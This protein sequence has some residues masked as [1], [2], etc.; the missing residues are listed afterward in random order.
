[1][2]DYYAPFSNGVAA[3]LK[4]DR[5][6]GLLAAAEENYTSKSLDGRE[7]K[8]REHSDDVGF[9]KLTM[10]LDED[11][12]NDIEGNLDEIAD[13]LGYSNVRGVRGQ[14]AVIIKEADTYGLVYDVYIGRNVWYNKHRLTSGW[15][16]GEDEVDQLLADLHD[17]LDYEVDIYVAE[18]PKAA[19]KDEVK[20]NVSG[21]TDYQEGL[22]GSIGLKDGV[23]SANQIFDI[24]IAAQEFAKK[25]EEIINRQPTQTAERR[26]GKNGC[27][28]RNDD[29][30]TFAKFGW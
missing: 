17:R 28:C 10:T 2:A 4:N 20:V 11:Y 14:R 30:P 29:E 23:L 26:L 9:I 5:L 8:N 25:I 7:L 16:S 21:L 13:V 24:T 22:I 3:A 27:G 6:Q 12:V 19:V 1:M 15:P 18:E